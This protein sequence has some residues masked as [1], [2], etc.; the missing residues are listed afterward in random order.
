MEG[1][2][3]RHIR[4]E[5]L[6]HMFSVMSGPDPIFLQLCRGSAPLMRTL[7]ASGRGPLWPGEVSPIADAIQR[8]PAF[9]LFS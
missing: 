1:L 5:P 4:T 6:I 8:E 9:H 3:G 7:R 2:K